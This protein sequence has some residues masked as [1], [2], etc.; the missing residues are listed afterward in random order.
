MEESRPTTLEKK[1]RPPGALC[2]VGKAPHGEASGVTA[3]MPAPA[4]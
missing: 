3:S 1:L 2:A 4:R